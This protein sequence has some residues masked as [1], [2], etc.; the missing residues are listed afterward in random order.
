MNTPSCNLKDIFPPAGHIQRLYC[1]TCGRHLRLT[2][3]DFNK[4][5]SEIGIYIKDLPVLHCD[6]CDLDYL[7]DDS[8]FAI[9]W[10]HEQA[11]KQGI[12]VIRATRRKPNLRYNFT[13]I[14]FDYDSDDYTNLPGLDRPHSGG[15]LTPV[16]FNRAVLLKY[17]ALPDYSVSFASSTYGNIDGPD[18][19]ISF[20]INKSGKVIMWLG[21]IA[22]LPENEQYYLRSENIPSDH[23]IGSEFY[24]GQIECIFTEL[25]KEKTAFANRSLFLEAAQKRFGVKIAHL[26][27][28]VLSLVSSLNAPITDTRN[29]RQRTADALNKIYVESFDNKAL[30]STMK[31]LGRDPKDLGT[32]KRLQSALEAIASGEDIAAIMLPFF[33]LYDFRVAALHLTSSE[34][35][36]QKLKTVTNRLQLK[37]DAT[38]GEIYSAILDGL[39]ASFT[40]MA[41][42]AE[43]S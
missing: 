18:F 37:E 7:P 24:D 11:I 32:L 12:S 16:F 42:I 9:I 6:A 20:G 27:D 23:D 40:R 36:A 33:T 22:K 39:S 3:I 10:H 43:R 19:Y 21:D 30:G 15:S 41:A 34:T 8:R 4:E 31:S 28:E 1:D 17:D 26:D 35:A 5:V 38:L 29:E 25:T 13:P 14:S 2:Y